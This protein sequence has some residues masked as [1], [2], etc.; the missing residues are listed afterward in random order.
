LE[1]WIST[2][3]TH[4]HHHDCSNLYDEIKINHAST[5]PVGD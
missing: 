2:H 3:I 1:S 5:S 4:L